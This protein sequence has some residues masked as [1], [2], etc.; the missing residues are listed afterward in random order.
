MA[1]I[2]NPHVS[3]PGGGTRPVTCTQCGT[4]TFE[5]ETAKSEGRWGFTQHK[6]TLLVCTHCSHIESFYDNRVIFTQVG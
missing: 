2:V 3:L 4:T 5:H 1:D 6:T